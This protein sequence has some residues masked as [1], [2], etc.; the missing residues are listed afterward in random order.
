MQLAS[1][2]G[3]PHPRFFQ[4]LW[5]FVAPSACMGDLVRDSDFLST[6][7]NTFFLH[8]FH[9]MPVVLSGTLL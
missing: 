3:T 9:Q 7:Q 4:E 2:C 6:L 8:L 5:S 1:P